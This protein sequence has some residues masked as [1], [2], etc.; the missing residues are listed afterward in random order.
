MEKDPALGKVPPHIT[1]MASQPSSANMLNTRAMGTA[2]TLQMHDEEQIALLLWVQNLRSEGI[3]VNRLLLKCKAMEVAQDLGFL[4]SQFKASSTWISGFIKRWKLSWRAKTRSGQ[5]NHSQGEATLAEFSQRIRQVV[6]ENEIDDIYNADQTDRMTAM[7]L[8]HTKVTKY[9]MF[10][11]LKSS[12]STVKKNVQ[13]NLTRRNGFGPRVWPESLSST[14]DMPR[15]CKNL[16]KVL[17]LWDDFSAHF[18]DEVVAYAP[19]CDVMLEKIPPTFTRICQ[20]A[21]VSWMKPMKAAMRKRWVSYLRAEIKHHS[22]S[23][24]GFRLLPPTRSDLVEWVNDAWENLP[25]AT[26]VNGFVKC[27]IIDTP[28]NTP[29]SNADDG[30]SSS[31]PTST[32]TQAND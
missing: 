13:E 9:P 19:S 10:L 22:S 5:S 32:Q 1:A 20:P 21:D 14:S 16:K 24:D 6:L 4:P 26:V 27:N 25:R 28:A 29:A 15:A 18:G 12:K 17:L 8:A 31:T 7:L 23:Q 11:V 30:T 2:T 3:P